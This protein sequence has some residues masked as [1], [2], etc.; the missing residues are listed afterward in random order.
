VKIKIFVYN[1]DNHKLIFNNTI[2]YEYGK[3]RLYL[4]V[5]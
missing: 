5:F 4:R 2:Y 3:K 1:N